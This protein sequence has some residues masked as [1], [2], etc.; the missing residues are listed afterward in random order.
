MTATVADTLPERAV[1]VAV[2]FLSALTKPVPS[3]PT[4]KGSALTQATVPP[5]LCPFWS[6]AVA[7][8][9]TRGHA[10]N[11]VLEDPEA[12]QRLPADEV[13]RAFRSF[14][15]EENRIEVVVKQSKSEADDRNAPASDGGS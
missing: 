9:D 2:P 15:S 13:V 3:T 5:K 10:R 4:T 14:Y 12:I 8:L 7:E 6:R 1:T 11:V